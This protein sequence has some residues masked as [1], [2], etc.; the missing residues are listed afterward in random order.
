M[1]NI[2]LKAVMV[3][4]GLVTAQLTFAANCSGTISNNAAGSL[5]VPAGSTCTLNGTAVEGSVT[6]QKGASLVLSNSSVSGNVQASTAKSV[7]LINSSV[8]GDVQ[9][10]STL[11]LDK[12]MITGN[13][14]CSSVKFPY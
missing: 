9:A 3:T 6:V 12:A 4:A 10:P 13:L 11:S 5:T 2:F 7:K 8:E 1:K 14:Y